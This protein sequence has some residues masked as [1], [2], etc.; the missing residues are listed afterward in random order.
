MTPQ[1]PCHSKGDRNAELAVENQ[2][3]GLSLGLGNGGQVS[4][5]VCVPFSSQLFHWD[6]FVSEGPQGIRS[7]LTPI[8]SSVGLLCKRE[9][10]GLCPHS[11]VPGAH[12]C[13]H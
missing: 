13:C 2:C 12:E 9:L 10:T 3:S 4:D 6:I 11:R 7:H 5:G 1:G 8:G